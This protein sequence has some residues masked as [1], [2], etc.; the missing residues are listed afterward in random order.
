MYGLPFKLTRVR[1]S[2]AE[3]FVMEYRNAKRIKG[4]WIDCE[5]NHPDYGWIPF[6]CDPNDK[7]ATFDVVTLHARMSADKSTLPYIPPTQAQLIAIKAGE[8]RAKRDALLAASDWSQL[9][10]APPALRA[11]WAAYRQALRDVPQQPG[12]PSSVTW[13]SPPGPDAAPDPRVTGV[14]FG[15]VMISATAADQAGLLAVLTAIQV[16]GASFKPTRFVFDNGTSV[17]ISLA[18]WQQLLAVWMPF[19]QSFFEVD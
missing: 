13:P 4:G 5:I 7:G 19:R 10:D 18:N 12:F 3:D 17:V 1:N 2:L 14:D 11:A 15:G 6:T 16:Q 9:P 8:V